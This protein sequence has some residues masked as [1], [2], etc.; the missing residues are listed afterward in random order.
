VDD[1]APL[2]IQADGFVFYENL[3]AAVND[4]VID[5][6]FEVF[7]PHTSVGSMTSNEG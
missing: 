2:P 6:W 4:G 7:V 3:T 1:D 5:L